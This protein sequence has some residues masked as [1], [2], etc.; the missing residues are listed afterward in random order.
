MAWLPKAK[1]RLD[2][3]R[4]LAQAPASLASAVLRGWA[5]ALVLAVF[6]GWA[7]RGA[8]AGAQIGLL[9]SLGLVRPLIVGD[10]AFERKA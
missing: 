5:Q 4:T 10:A 1:A 8:G 2:R 9:A 7:A 6:V 3:L